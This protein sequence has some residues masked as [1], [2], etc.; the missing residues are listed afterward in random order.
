MTRSVIKI[1]FQVS[2]SG[3]MAA[4]WWIKRHAGIPLLALTWFKSGTRI[5]VS[6]SYHTMYLNQGIFIGN[7]STARVEFKLIFYYN[8]A[9]IY[10]TQIL[11]DLL[12]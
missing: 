7:D 12:K 2:N 1:T 11:I 8:E 9:E 5:P 10:I 4:I 6:V 3:A